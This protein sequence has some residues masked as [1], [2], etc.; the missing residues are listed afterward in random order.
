VRTNQ[1][2]PAN[3]SLTLADSQPNCITGSPP[4]LPL[5]AQRGTGHPS[6]SKGLRLRKRGD[7]SSSPARVE[8]AC[9]KRRAH[10]VAERGHPQHVAEEMLCN[11]VGSHAAPPASSGPQEFRRPPRKSISQPPKGARY[12]F[13]DVPHNSHHQPASCIVSPTVIVSRHSTGPTTV[14][15]NAWTWHFNS[16]DVPF[17]P[18]N[19]LT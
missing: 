12:L 18:L 7:D 16:T 10:H 5:N 13:Q 3:P 8:I 14:S 19:R 1:T 2:T 15:K 9:Q 6:G 11:R 17:R 4:S